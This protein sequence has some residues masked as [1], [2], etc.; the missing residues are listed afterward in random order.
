MTGLDNKYI[1]DEV[2]EVSEDYFGP[3]AN[4]F[5]DRIISNHLKKPPNKITRKDIKNIVSWTK[6]A[7]GLITSN[8]EDIDE[9][10][11]RLEKLGN[12]K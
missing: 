7:L 10:I 8:Q 12:N 9:F 11:S 2:V 4:R 6:L 5:I 1:Y 3:A